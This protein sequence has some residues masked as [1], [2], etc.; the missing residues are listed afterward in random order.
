VLKLLEFLWSGCW[1]KW[2]DLKTVEVIQ[3]ES[4]YPYASTTWTRYYT[5]CTRCGAHKKWD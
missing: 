4:A 1:H 3:R 2:E 5:R